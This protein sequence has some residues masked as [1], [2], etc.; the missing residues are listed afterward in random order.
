MADNV[1][2]T[3]GSGATG[4]TDEIGGVHYPRV[5]LALGADGTASDAPVGGGVE[6]GA[7][8][9]TIANDSTGVLSIDD[10]GSSITV[11]GTVTA[12]LSATDNAVLD[13]IETNT[14]FGTV[15]GG[16]LEASAL[17]VTLAS[18]ST[19]VVSIDDNGGSLTVDGTVTA[20][21]SATDN[22][23]LD[24]I[25]T[26]VELIDNAISGTEMQVDVVA[27]L[28]TGSN[29]IG[30]IFGSADTGE[31]TVTRPADT[32]AYA[33]GDVWADS[34]SAP[35]AGGFTLSNMARISGGS[36]VITDLIL[37]SG[38]ANSTLQGQ[39]L[40]F[41]AAVTAVNDNA[42]LTLTDAEALDLV[43]VV[44]FNFAVGGVSATN[45]T[46]LSLSNLGISYKCVGSANLRFLIRVAAAYTPTSAETLAVKAKAIHTD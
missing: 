30:G 46:T 2:F 9:V 13:T 17:R 31:A 43:A 8:R 45:N 18:D 33:A 42:A 11:D 26:A 35:T 19:G 4:A 12:N 37:V 21:L 14:D 28:P 32:T 5:K 20:N 44:P 25:Q 29:V 39:I 38:V 41:D 15:T 34:T 16:G 40:I 3:P 27:A 23:V 7:L 22:A 1:A 10:N 36:G 24:N 6:S